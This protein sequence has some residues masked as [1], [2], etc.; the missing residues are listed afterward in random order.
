M[1]KITTYASDNGLN[2][3]LDEETGTVEVWLPEGVAACSK[4]EDIDD[5]VSVLN[6]ASYELAYALRRK[7]ERDAAAQTIV[8]KALVNLDDAVSDADEDLPF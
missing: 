2:V 8:V 7:A 5:M 3:S 1:K 4:V 6:N